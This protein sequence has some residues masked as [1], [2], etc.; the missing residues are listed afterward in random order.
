MLKSQPRPVEQRQAQIDLKMYLSRSYQLVYPVL[1][2]LVSE[3]RGSSECF[4]PHTLLSCPEVTQTEQGCSVL[5]PAWSGF[6]HLLLCLCLVSSH[7]L[8]VFAPFSPFSAPERPARC[9]GA[10][11]EAAA[12]RA[13]GGRRAGGG[14]GRRNHGGAGPGRGKGTGKGRRPRAR[15]QSR[16]RDRASSL[17][18]RRARGRPPA[19]RRRVPPPRGRPVCPGNPRGAA[20]PPSGPYRAVRGRTEPYRA[21]PGRG[22][23]GA[24]GP[25]GRRRRHGAV[26]GGAA[27][28]P[29]GTRPVPPRGARGD[30]Q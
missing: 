2:L 29:A 5:A 21:V 26:R 27:S 25:R 8:S 11:G 30:G 24:P 15:E 16:D 1:S 7:G 12:G 3:D 13:G 23:G 9:R 17:G 19:P 22:A 20:A 18:L 10:F 6:F 14:G 28:G 4:P